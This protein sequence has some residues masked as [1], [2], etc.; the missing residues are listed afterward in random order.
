MAVGV[1]LKMG[2]VNVRT[3][4]YPSE[5]SFVSQVNKGMRDIQKN[6]E[7]VIDQFENVTPE[8]MKD[9]LQ[10]IFDKSQEYVPKRT[11][12]LMNSGYLEVTEK[13]QRPYVELGYAKGGKPGYAAYVHENIEMPHAQPT[14]SKFLEA[15]INEEIGTAIDRIEAGYRNFMGV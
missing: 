4:G 13:G 10:P 1:R 6:L 9:A 11:R 3:T 5:K 14:R 2:K 12:A 15:A 8:I 7:W